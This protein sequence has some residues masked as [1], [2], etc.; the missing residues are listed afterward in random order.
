MKLAGITSLQYSAEIE[1]ALIAPSVLAA[2]RAVVGEEL[3]LNLVNYRTP[4]P[5]GQGQPLHDLSRRRGRPFFKCNAIW[6]LDDFTVD[7][8][9]TRVIPGSHLDDTQ[10]KERMGDPYDVHVDEVVVEAPKGSVVFHNSHLIHSGRP[11]VSGADRRSIHAA[12]TGPS[13]PTHYDWTALPE[14]ITSQFGDQTL[15]LLGLRRHCL[16]PN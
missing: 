16:S 14:H 8:G 11:N 10:A 3:L 2:A 13:E 12:Y 4:T 9:A 15:D 6:C 7:N 1:R 5:G